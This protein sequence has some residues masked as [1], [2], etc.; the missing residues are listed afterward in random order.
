MIVNVDLAL[1]GMD[2][3]AA[4]R[5]L[6]YPYNIVLFFKMNNYVFERCG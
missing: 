5:S 3:H 6:Q 4:V 1:Q 2:T